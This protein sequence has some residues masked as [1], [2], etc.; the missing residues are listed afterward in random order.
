MHTDSKPNEPHSRNEDDFAWERFAK[1]CL[2]N[3]YAL[4]VGSEAILDQKIYPETKG[5]STQLIFHKTLFKIA[6]S[7]IEEEHAD[8]SQTILD[9]E[10]LDEYNRLKKRYK[11]YS[12]LGRRYNDIKEQ[13]INA[14]RQLMSD[15]NSLINSIEPSLRQLLKTRCFRIVITTAIDPF[16]E[17]AME[18][19]WG[20]NGF[21]VIQVETAKSTFKLVTYEEFNVNRPVLCYMFGKIDPKLSDEENSFVL[22]END[23]IKKIA[24]WFDAADSNAFLKYIRN[25]SLCSVGPQFND[26]MFRFFW[27]LLR[28]EIG[29]NSGNK[30]VAVENEHED[31]SLVS[32]LEME[33]V[34]VFPDAREF[35][36]SA[37]KQ[38]NEAVI[39]LREPRKDQGVFIS[40]SHRDRYIAMPLFERLR[41]ESIP[42]WIDDEELD[43]GDEFKDRIT[44][45]IET[46]KIFLPILSTTIRKQISENKIKDQWYY[47]N[48]WCLIEERY[49]EE[50]KKQ[51]ESRKLENGIPQKLSFKTIPFIVG[52]Y[53][54][55]KEYH[56]SLPNCIK[57]ASI[58][59]PQVLAKGRIDHLIEI[60]KEHE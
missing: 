9:N 8:N 37:V 12:H 34:K 48:E 53:N 45:A 47:K 55:T 25:Y 59:D 18:E 35:M 42:V 11:N 22:S 16:L 41:S 56:Q 4:V 60:I 13:V 2:L 33:K 17:L 21:D 43:D 23:A 49:N 58:K 50:K 44:N 1:N 7:N 51:E 54:Y 29:K 19:V 14:T 30:Q 38:I 39:S 32:Y 24:K 26:W 27:Y 10:I 15:K 20:E 31:S 28:G 3:K 52:D 46:C 5:N 57:N 36:A 6:T 40:Y